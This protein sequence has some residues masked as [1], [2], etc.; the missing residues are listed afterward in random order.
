MSQPLDELIAQAELGEEA[1]KFL[2]SDLCKVLIGFARQEVDAAQE[3][4]ETADP[5]DTKKIISLQVNA[6]VGRLFEQW[7][8]SL[9]DEGDNALAVFK[10]QQEN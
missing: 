5:T 10:Q 1:R 9:V 2:Q 8:N 3:E 7:I 6:R 4:L